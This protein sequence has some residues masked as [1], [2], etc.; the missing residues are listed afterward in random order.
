M[1]SE[2]SIVRAISRRLAVQ[3]IAGAAAAATGLAGLRPAFARGLVM[4]F[5]YVGP[6]DD[7]GYNQ[8]HAEGAAAVKKMAGVK[9]LEEEKVPET[10]AV[11]QSM[12]SMINLDGASVLFPTSFGYWSPYVL[13]LAAKYPNI[14]F[15][16]AGGLW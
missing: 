7:F 5:L 10:N 2:P 16:H 13:A 12:E 11:A 4:G 15:R 6:R 14:Q 9:V 3:G 1:T 8:A